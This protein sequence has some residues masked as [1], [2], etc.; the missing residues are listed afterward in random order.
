MEDRPS[1]TAWRVARRRAAHQILDRP[2][3]HS[4]GLAA[5]IVAGGKA[6][7]RRPEDDP[8]ELTRLGRFLRAFLAVR[9][10]FAE[11]ELAAAVARGVRQYVVLGAGLDTSAFRLQGTDGLRIFEV[12]HPATQSWK[13]A[14]LARSGIA[15]SDSVAFVPLDFEKET[16]AEG[17]R[18]AGFD[19]AAPA[20][21]SWLG[22]VPYLGRD[23]IEA[24]LAFIAS[25]PERSEV[26]FDYG[27]PPS[28]LGFLERMAFRRLAR[29]VAA[30][31]ERFR[32]FFDPEPLAVL[33]RGIGFGEIEDLG[34]ADIN[35]R[36]FAGREDGLRVGRAGRLVA[37]RR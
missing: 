22:V 29:R 10:R 9:S 13:R 16:L 12:D 34:P 33:L 26:V 7:A 35:A 14:V 27:I 30:A 6:S 25:L 31:G 24:T 37:A 3:V 20:F 28:R 23:A 18:T 36:Y 2:V 32:T 17:L 11:D 15:V 8:R 5:V 21:F 19:A 4:D 1:V